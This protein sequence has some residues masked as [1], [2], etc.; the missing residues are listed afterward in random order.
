M[1]TPRFD[2]IHDGATVHVTWRCLEQ[3]FL[4]GPRWAKQLYCQL[5]LRHK[6]RYGVRIHAYCILD[7]HVHLTVFM[8][9]AVEFSRFLQY[10]HSTFVLQYNHKV[11]RS[12]CLIED[13]PKTKLIQD[14]RQE[15]TTLIYGD[16]N[17]TRTVLRLH[18]SRWE[19]SSYHY[20]AEGR[21]DPLVDESPCY[22]AL[23]E[24]PEDRRAVY[25][26]QVEGV[27]ENIEEKRLQFE[28]LSGPGHFLGDQAWVQEHESHLRQS[29]EERRAR[30]AGR[31]D[32]PPPWNA[33]T[34]EQR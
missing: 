10:V 14:E 12:G 26:E 27:V 30:R 25:S 32:F 29:I 9:K 3:R 2:I 11:G 1:R 15:L 19:F 33:G 4:L 20:Y 13:R 34:G 8:E 31:R 18:P 7:N 24:G 16:T 23:G 6:R 22:T 17:P 28:A 5:L 21:T